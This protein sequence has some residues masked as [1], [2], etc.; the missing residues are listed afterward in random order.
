[1]KAAFAELTEKQIDYIE[2]A[3]F[4]R[5]IVTKSDI[6]EA[7]EVLELEGKAHEQLTAIRNAV[8]RHL[9]DLKAAKRDTG[10]WAEFDRLSNNI[11]AIT[12]AIDGLLY[13]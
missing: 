5:M 4:D 1:M 11:S 12:C 6:A 3:Q 10:D 8:V 13:A 2:S 9:A 7:T